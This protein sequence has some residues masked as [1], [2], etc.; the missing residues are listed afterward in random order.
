M[1]YTSI[2]IIGITG[3]LARRQLLPALYYLVADNKL[4]SFT[5][6]GCAQEATTAAAIWQ[7]AATYI[8]TADSSLLET[9]IKQTTYI[10]LDLY[11]PR[12]VPN[13]LYTTI[14][15]Q[16]AIHGTSNRLVYCAVPSSF[17]ATITTLCT[18]Y[19]IIVRQE[20]TTTPWHRIVYEKPFGYDAY[21]AQQ[22]NMVIAQHIQEQQIF[23]IDHYL[24][25]EI[26]SNITLLRFTNCIF[27]PL[28]NHHF[29]NQIHI[30]A[31]ETIGIE[32]RGTYYDTYGAV[33]DVVQN[34]IL[35]LLAL[36]AMESPT[37]RTGDSVRDARRTVLE[38]T[39]CT[40]G[41]YGQYDGY[42]QESQVK[43]NSNTETFALLQFAINTP[44]WHG[45]PFYSKVGKML[46]RKETVI[47]VQFK[48]VTCTLTASCPPANWLTISIAPEGL[49]TITLNAKQPGHSS[50]MLM[51][52][53]LSFCHS[54]QFTLRPTEAYEQALLEI[55]RGEQSAAVRFD[56]IAASWT[57][58]DALRN[59]QFPLYR[60]A[61]YSEGPDE[62]K[63]FSHQHT[64]RWHP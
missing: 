32:N 13:T 14:A 41:I 1:N 24:T 36:M 16:E 50:G 43:H 46:N 7:N 27:E 52:I 10:C 11:N 31:T 63:T 58:I 15:A 45:V 17:F 53:D 6:I 64:I 8:A 51:P 60:Y 48:A 4:H 39:T 49:F 23:R 5:I 38:H 30:I 57:I 12:D 35:Q 28:W 47:H 42:K 20:P 22:I 25:K 19:G 2:I 21:S 59:K 29:I 56:E 40:D 33:R 62:I 54:C 3:D 44:R 18:Q 34:H 37:Q 55:M 9:L 26:V 61:P